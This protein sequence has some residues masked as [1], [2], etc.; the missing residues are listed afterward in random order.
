MAHAKRPTGCRQREPGLDF[1]TT[2]QHG[3]YGVGC[4]G[5]GH[6]VG[7]DAAVAGLCMQ[8]RGSKQEALLWK[9]RGSLPWVMGQACVSSAEGKLELVPAAL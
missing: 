1:L 8:Q 3:P 6:V 9:G 4:E 2:H 7:P 5:Q